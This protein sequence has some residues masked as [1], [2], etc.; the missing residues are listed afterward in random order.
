MLIEPVDANTALDQTDD[1][2]LSVCGAVLVPMS[3]K[4]IPNKLIKHSLPPPALPTPPMLTTPDQLER[5]NRFSVQLWSTV[6]AGVGPVRPAG[7]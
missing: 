1:S 2:E 3:R 4:S 7:I 6:R 5:K